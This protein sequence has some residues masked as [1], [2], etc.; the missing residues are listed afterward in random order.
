MMNHE[1]T[2]YSS[3]LSL[4]IYEPKSTI[5]MKANLFMFDSRSDGG[6]FKELAENSGYV[7]VEPSY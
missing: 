7:F 6:P 5:D 3:I 2:Q 1:Q 4:N